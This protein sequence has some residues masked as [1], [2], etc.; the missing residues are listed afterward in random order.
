MYGTKSTLV[1]TFGSGFFQNCH[2]T[3]HVFIAV[4]E[5][6]QW[7]HEADWWNSRLPS[8]FF[9][10]LLLVVSGSLNE[11]LHSTWRVH[12]THTTDRERGINNTATARREGERNRE[13]GRGVGNEG[14]DTSIFSRFL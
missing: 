10:F 11:Q 2:R 7:D 14:V 6:I 4:M 3:H 9:L 8:I 1:P 12:R 5:A 13:D